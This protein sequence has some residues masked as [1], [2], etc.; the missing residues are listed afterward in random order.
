MKVATNE[1]QKFDITIIEMKSQIKLTITKLIHKTS[2]RGVAIRRR[3]F[4]W[5]KRYPWKK[6][7]QKQSTARSA[8]GN[9]EYTMEN[10]R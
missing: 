3:L 8:I 5:G 10:H 1:T 4:A 2:Q 7:E 9:V 6:I